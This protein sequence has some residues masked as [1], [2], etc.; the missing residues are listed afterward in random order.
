M[1]NDF[2]VL[3]TPFCGLA[4]YGNRCWSSPEQMLIEKLL[5]K[6]RTFAWLYSSAETAADS[7]LQMIVS[8]SSPAAIPLLPAGLFVYW[9]FLI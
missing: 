5:M 6:I 7:D 1:T 9:S 8:T 2:F 3:H 4:K